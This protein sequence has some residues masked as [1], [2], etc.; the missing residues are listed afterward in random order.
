ME[1]KRRVNLPNLREQ[2]LDEVY[3]RDE[4]AR[5]QQQVETLTQQLAASMAQHQDPNLQDVEEE[6]EEDENPFAHQPVQ[7]RPAHDESRRWETSL[8]V[9][10]PEFHGGLQADEYL[11][12]INTGD[13]VLEFKQVPDDR[14]VALVATRLRG[15]AGAWWQQVKKARTLQ[16]KGKITSWDKMKKNMRSAF[17]PYNYT[18]TLYQRLQNLRQG[19]RSVNDYTTEFYQLVS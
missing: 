2:P 4:I 14:R 3:E 19:N 9:D 13:E 16:G 10:I 6:S 5:L 7:R 11:D 12:W 17:L 1:P 15:R 8:K 18:R